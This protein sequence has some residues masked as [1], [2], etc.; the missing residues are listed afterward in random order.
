MITEFYEPETKEPHVK[1]EDFY[2]SVFNADEDSTDEIDG[3]LHIISKKDGSEIKINISSLI[4][5]L[6]R[7]YKVTL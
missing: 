5:E 1:T 4:S 2:F 3:Y 7:G 6:Q